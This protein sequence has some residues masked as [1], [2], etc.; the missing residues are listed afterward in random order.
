MQIMMVCMRSKN[1]VGARVSARGGSQFESATHHT[2]VTCACA[3]AC[4]QPGIWIGGGRATYGRLDPRAIVGVQA[5]VHEDLHR[6]DPRQAAPRVQRVALEQGGGK[7]LQNR[8][9]RPEEQRTQ[10]VAVYRHWGFQ[11]FSR[12]APRYPQQRARLSRVRNVSS[13]RGRGDRNKV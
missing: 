4:R 13:R 3:R 6:H 2:T 12:A 11:V 9:Q 7:D 5:V 8:Y 10:R 1:L